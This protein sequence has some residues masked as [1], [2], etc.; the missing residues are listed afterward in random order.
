MANRISRVLQRSFVSGVIL[1]A[2]LVVTL[3]VLNL[4]FGWLTGAVDPIVRYLGLAKYTADV[5]LAARVVAILLLVGAIT[6]VGYVAQ[7]G[8]GRRL[9]GRMGRVMNVVPLVSVI[10]GSVRQVADSL[11]ERSSRYEDVV[12]VEYPHHESY[13]I[14]FVTSEAPGEIE[15]TLEREA[16][17]VYVPNSPNPTGGRLLVVPTERLHHTELSVRRALRTTVSTGM[18]TEETADVLPDVGERPN[19]S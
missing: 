19:E 11:M 16:K 14:G 18:A 17:L 8:F 15:A 9:F 3:F 5:E 12:L 6:A 4:V 13:V 2:P 10:Y 7:R 1:V